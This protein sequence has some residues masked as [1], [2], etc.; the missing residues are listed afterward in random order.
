M[1]KVRKV[2]RKLVFILI[3]V[4]ALAPILT[5]MEV[6]AEDVS[7][8]GV[9]VLDEVQENV[10]EGPK[11]RAAQCTIT[12][13]V[14]GWI[15]NEYKIYSYNYISGDATLIFSGIVGD[16]SFNISKQ[17]S[18]ENGY[19]VEMADGS[20]LTMS[21]DSEGNRSLNFE[22]YFGKPS[23]PTPK[24][25]V[26]PTPKPTVTPTPK[27]TVTPTPKPTVVAKPV[28]PA[29]ISATTSAAKAATI[30]W[31]R[32]ANATGYEILRSNK[33]TSG[34]KSIK[35]IG[36][37]ATSFKDTSVVE[38]KTYYYKVRAKNS[39]GFTD[40]SVMTVKTIAKTTSLKL[41]RSGNN[42]KVSYKSSEKNFQI[43]VSTKKGSS[44]KNVATN[45]KKKSL[46]VKNSSIKKALKLKKDKSYTLYV[47]TR[48]FRVVNNKKVYGSW[49]TSK[50]IK[51]FK[52][53]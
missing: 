32:V 50:A 23:T 27:P 5:P 48:S 16:F 28:A 12:V 24:P 2:F 9:V 21:K 3:A 31:K 40:S 10:K 35:S 36:A 43:Q 45:N 29:G 30:S 49:T 44:Y 34:F 53:K 39:G 18:D 7:E 33:K 46:T 26:T 8:P 51:N 13:T 15:N 17:E 42:L 11:V 1:E 6:W 19:Y 22:S 37:N 38:G 41:N 20:E 47:R 52:I 4:F 14:G 25:T